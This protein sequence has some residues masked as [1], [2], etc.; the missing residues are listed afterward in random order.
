VTATDANFQGLHVATFES[1]R[2]EEMA[3][4]IERFG[5]VPH[6]APSL[7]EV[8]LDVNPDAVDFANL[9]ITGQIDVVVLMTGVGTRHLLAQVERHVDRQ[10][11]LDALSDVVTI[12]RGPKPTAILREWGLTPKHRAPE[13]NTWREVLATIDAGVPINNLT[14]GVQE[15]GKPNVSLTAGLEARGAAVRTV[16]VYG[17]DF[18]LDVGPLQANLR[19]LVA[20]KI[21][22][23]MFTSA[24]QVVNVLR[25]AEELGLTDAVRDAFERIVVASI[26]PTTSEALQDNDIRVDLEPEHGKM[27]H[28]VQAAAEKAPQIIQQRR[29]S[30]SSPTSSQQR[31]T[32]SVT[33]TAVPLDPAAPVATALDKSAPWYD[34]PFLRACRREPTNVTPVWLMRQ[35]GRYMSEYRDVRAKTTF[36][37]LCKD[38]ALCA[39]VMITAVTRLGVDAAIIFSDLLPMLEPMGVQLEFA[40]GEG[41]VI[42]NPVREPKDVERIFELENMDALQ[43]VAETVRQTR[44]GL[45]GNIPVIGFAGAPFTLASYVIEGGGSRSYLNAKRLMYR[46]PAAWHELMTKLSRSITRY[47]NMQIAAGAQ[48]VQL[49]DSWVGCLGPDDYRRYVLPYIKAIV[50]GLTPGAPLI[51]FGTGNP[52]L[53]PLYAEGGGDVIG[54]DWRVRLDEAWKTV[55]YDRAVQGNLEPLVL[56]AEPKTIRERAK[57]VLDQAGGRPGHIFNL[58]HG[59]VPQT[60]VDNV[61][62][63]I[64][65]VHELSAR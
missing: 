54:I 49:F 13:P 17:Y 36:L 21:D 63:L 50:A 7:R 61:I 43:F 60:P 59:I 40:A 52:A 16:K 5:G 41:P 55:G 53:L 22:V 65:A 51:N 39:E 32:N 20:G 25:M 10:R 23:V 30:P 6:V 56:L 45:P 46:E 18:P 27:G 62:A 1:R 35:A 15:Y 37:D 33:V 14:V 19:D 48:A 11:F 31:M 28:L 26:G 64:D 24:H 29:H 38:P 12:V 34:S 47:L 57:D 44:A 2:A 42:H 58:G 9:L 3:R 4:L 8:G